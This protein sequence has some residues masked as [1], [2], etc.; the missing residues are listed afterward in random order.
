MLTRG[1]QTPPSGPGKALDDLIGQV[2]DSETFRTAPVMRSLLLYLWKH[3]GEPI[4]EYAIAVDALGRSP[5]FDPKADSTVRVQVARLRTKLKDFYANAGDAF[6]LRVSIPVGRHDLTYT[7]TPPV[8]PAKLSALRTTPSVLLWVGGGLIALLSVSTLVLLLQNRALK[9]SAPAPLPPLWQTF[10]ANGKP[11]LVVVPSPLYFFWPDHRVYV[12]D[13]SISEFPKWSNS[14]LLR[15]LGQKWGAPELAQTY[16][17][18]MEMS[19]GVRFLQYLDKQP[20]GAELVESRKFSTDAFADRNIIF[21]G[22]PR[23]T[24]GYLDRLLEKTTFYMAEAGSGRH[25]EP[26]RGFH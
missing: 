13:L 3:Q 18:A 21:L 26:S 14:A 25:P 6:P 22:M 15:E 2:A 24:A 9:A 12:R 8:R 17:G 23:T 20:S 5:D 19:S 1:S 10:A 7:Y 4:S 16:V 11:S